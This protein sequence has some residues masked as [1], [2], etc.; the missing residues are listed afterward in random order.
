MVRKLILEELNSSKQANNDKKKSYAV[1]VNK[2]GLKHERKDLQNV[3]T[4][5]QVEWNIPVSQISVTGKRRIA[6]NK[7]LKFC[8][9]VLCLPFPWG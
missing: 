9:Q 6:D 7:S 2:N 3:S 4:D 1:L 8:G 5:Y